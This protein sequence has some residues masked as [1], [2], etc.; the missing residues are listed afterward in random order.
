MLQISLG[1]Y[2][3]MFGPLPM[4][5]SNREIRQQGRFMLYYRRLKQSNKYDDEMYVDT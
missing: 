3:C 4:S 2:A 1:H 5:F